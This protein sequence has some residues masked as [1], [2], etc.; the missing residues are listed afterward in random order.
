[1]LNLA[2]RRTIPTLALLPCRRTSSLK[3][4]T[5]STTVLLLLIAFLLLQCPVVALLVAVVLLV[6]QSRRTPLN[7]ATPV[8]GTRL[9]PSPRN[10][11]R[12]PTPRNHR[13]DNG[14]G[15]SGWGNSNN[16]GWGTVENDGWGAAADDGWEAWPEEEQNTSQN[17]VEWNSTWNATTRRTTTVSWGAPV[18]TSSWRTP[19]YSGLYW[20]SPT[21]TSS[22]GVGLTPD[23]DPIHDDDE[24]DHA[25]IIGS[26]NTHRRPS[27]FRPSIL[28]IV[29]TNTPPT[30]SPSPEPAPIPA[31]IPSSHL[32]T[33]E[34]F[35][36]RVL[37]VQR[38]RALRAAS[39]SRNR[40]LRPD[41]APQTS[42][43]S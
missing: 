4:R 36:L 9:V 39:T 40:H 27:P 30:P 33:G 26:N 41:A 18:T 12:T 29:S 42:E 7:P 35:H 20:N 32:M 24:D 11:V 8:S 3:E 6:R 5:M 23:G 28:P 14:W 19:A 17:N 22:W 15:N 38:R 43:E 34:P 16:D 13:N 10:P 2:E 37:R 25:T 21:N 1:M 31:P